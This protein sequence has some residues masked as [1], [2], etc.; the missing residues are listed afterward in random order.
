M[1]NILPK[2]T[3]IGAH[4]SSSGGLSNAI[5]NANNIGANSIQI[6]S[7]PPQMWLPTKHSQE[8]I[9][10]FVSLREKSDIEEVWIHNIY[11]ANMAADSSEQLEKSI[12]SVIGALKFGE[13]IKAAGVV[14]HT[15]S[16][17]GKGFNKVQRKVINSLKKIL[18]SVPIDIKLA[19]ENAAGQGGSIGS[20]FN[21]LEYI[22]ERVNDERIGICID[23]CHAFAAGYDIRK[24]QVIEDLLTSFEKTIT[25][26]K[27]FVVHAND[28]LMDL[29]SH[30]DRHQ[31]IG[32]GFIGNRGFKN[33]LSNNYFKKL[34]FILEVPGFSLDNTKKNKGPDLENI[35][36]LKKLRP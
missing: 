11:L 33:L 28:S 35:K 32:E 3:S 27:I 20:D 16:H 12:N 9:D 23:T 25:K 4:V 34:C 17:K 6:F 22:I 15:G 13:K 5:V 18:S 1:E 29:G 30:R 21:E 36:R 26:E 19:L 7:G 14:L 24:K 10:Q 31:N 2:K 8:T